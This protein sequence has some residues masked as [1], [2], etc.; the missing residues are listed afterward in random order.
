MT[1]DDDE[2][3]E[4]ERRGE[5]EAQQEEAEEPPAV[6]PGIS[7]F[8]TFC[9]FGSGSDSAYDVPFYPLLSCSFGTRQ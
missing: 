2:E 4:R 5:E 7:H 1:S 8:L 6:Y 3:D 9:A